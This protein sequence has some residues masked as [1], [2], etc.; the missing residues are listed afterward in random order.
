MNLKRGFRAPTDGEEGARELD[1]AVAEQQDD[2][3]VKMTM[4]GAVKNDNDRC[5]QK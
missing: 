1:E 3:R 2:W 5:G 4:T